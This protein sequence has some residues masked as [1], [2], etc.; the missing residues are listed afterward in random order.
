[1]TRFCGDAVSVRTK[2]TSAYTGKDLKK[3][4]QKFLETGG[5]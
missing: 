4:M 2:G 5:T 3:N 1:M